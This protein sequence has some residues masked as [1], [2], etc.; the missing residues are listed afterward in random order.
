MANFNT[1]FPTLLKHEGGYVNDPDDSGGATNKGV[2]IAVFRKWRGYPASVQELKN[3]SDQEAG[4]IYKKLYWDKIYGD[5]IEDQSL[6]EI[7][8]DHAVNAGVG[9]AVKILQRILNRKGAGLKVDGGFGPKTFNALNRQDSQDVY[10]QFLEARYD[11]YQRIV[12]RKPK[13]KKFLKIWLNRLSSFS[14]KKVVTGVSVTIALMLAGMYLYS[15]QLEKNR[16]E[17]N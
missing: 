16:N 4:Q 15:R 17:K 12:A 5:R 2:T 13:L 1:Y 9:S 6:A 8:F 14:K 10:N 11:F 7:I 3:L